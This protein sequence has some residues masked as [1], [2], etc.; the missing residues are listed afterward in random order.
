MGFTKLDEDFFDSSLVAEGPIPTAVFVLLLAKAKPDGIARV[1]SS[2]VGG[3][4]GLTAEQTAQAFA[5][6][7]GPDPHSRSLEHDGARIKRVDG[8]WLILNYKKRREAGIREAVREYDRERKRARI[9]EASG[10]LPESSASSSPS[11][12]VSVEGGVG[13]TTPERPDEA[14]ERK[15]RESKVGDERAL[16]GLVARL[17]ACDPK[18]RSAAEL[19]QLVTSYDKADGRRVGGCVNPATLSYERVRK[20]LADAEALLRQWGGA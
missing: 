11:V 3:R 9:P 8:G 17:E 2:V 6:L 4:L 13:G 7:E 16:L 10:G 18:G 12:S 20:S 1:A 19:M 14:A 15:I 5:L